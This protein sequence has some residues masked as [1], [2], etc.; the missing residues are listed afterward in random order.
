MRDVLYEESIL[1]ENLKFKKTLY[2]IY[3]ILFVI[4]IALAILFSLFGLYDW[5][6]LIVGV[7]FFGVA[8]LL[9]FLRNKIYYCVDCIFVSGSTR[10][11]RVVNFKKRKKIIAEAIYKRLALNTR[12]GSIRTAR[13]AARCW[14]YPAA[15]IPPSR[16]RSAARRSGV[17]A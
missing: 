17:T 8:A 15:R 14:A 16:R 4:N 7:S 13:A 1:P 5:G 2:V 10:L 3:Q 11:I 9:A 6:I 12:T